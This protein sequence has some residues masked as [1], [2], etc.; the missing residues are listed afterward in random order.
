MQDPILD[1]QARDWLRHLTSGQAT[2][3]DVKQFEQWRDA[4]AEHRAA[5][6]SARRTWRDLGDL[7]R[8][9][10]ERRP[11]EQPRRSRRRLILGAGLA[12][13]GAAATALA[14]FP[15]MALWPSLR[16][17]GADYRTAV[18]EQRR[19]ALA[20][21]VHVVMNTRTSLSAWL[22]AGQQR[23]E[24]L[25]G[26]AAF[27]CKDGDRSLEILA[28]DGSIRAGLASLDVRRLGGSV[29]VTCLDGQAEVLHGG[30]RLTLGPRQQVRYNGQ[31][32]LPIVAVANPS[33]AASWRN[34]VVVIDNLPLPD[35]IDEINRY[36]PGR[37]VLVNDRLAG[38]RLSGRFPIG[39]LDVALVQIERLLGATLRYGPAGLVLIA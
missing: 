10:R 2:G 32:M 9:W 20:G 29:W 25:E 3:R 30:R 18:G 5:W 22:E 39:D 36:R 27:E 4:S 35:A 6:N 1:K 38:R 13:G 14:M 26:E 17:W 23:I 33:A 34:G 12:A 15:P 7:G 16:E 8:A 28:G 37:V 31:D 21:D 11:A 24:L 19:L